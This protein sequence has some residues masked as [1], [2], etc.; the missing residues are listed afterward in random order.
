MWSPCSHHIEVQTTILAQAWSSA[1]RREQLVS[2]SQWHGHSRHS[3]FPPADRLLVYSFLSTLWSWLWW[4]YL[5][6]AN[7]HVIVITNFIIYSF[8]L[9]MFNSI[10]SRAILQFFRI[11]HTWITQLTQYLLWE[12][13]MGHHHQQQ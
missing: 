11:S 5:N 4:S 10:W 1:A 9:N 6:F 13:C 3:L 12:Q 8:P 2:P 7:G